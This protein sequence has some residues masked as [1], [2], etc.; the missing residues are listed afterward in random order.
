MKILL[1]GLGKMGSNHLRILTEISRGGVKDIGLGVEVCGVVDTNTSRLTEVAEKHQLQPFTNLKEAL[2]NTQADAVVIAAPTRFHF[3][4]ASDVLKRRIPLL[5]EKPIASSS[6]DGEALC[7]L[8]FENQTALMIGHVERFNPAVIHAYELIR[9]GVLGEVVNISTKRVGGAPTNVE[10]SGDVLIDLGVHDIDIIQWLLGSTAE[11]KGSI[12]HTRESG[13][14]DSATL[15]LR[16]G[17]CTANVHMDWVTPVKIREVQITGTLGFLQL[18]LITQKATFTHKN[19]ALLNDKAKY[20]IRFEKYLKWFATPDQ[21]EAQIEK[22]EPLFEEIKSFVESV[23]QGT[24]VRVSGVESLKALKIA[25]EA[26]NQVEKE[27]QI[28][29]SNQEAVEAEQMS[30][31]MLPSMTLLKRRVS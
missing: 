25:E 27:S 6:K 12:G 5:L 17:H 14:I 22:K 8:A 26:R 20:D 10:S 9:Q 2:S 18:N 1:C 19:P 15:L 28:F 23:V 24:S 13:H 16:C 29:S 21:A 30:K 4:L 31:D 3:D 11:L 7:R